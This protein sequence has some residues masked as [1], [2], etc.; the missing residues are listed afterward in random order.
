M[1]IIREYIHTKDEVRI[2]G[3][4]S[5]PSQIWKASL[6]FSLNLALK[7]NLMTFQVNQNQRKNVFL[8]PLVNPHYRSI[9]YP[10]KINPYKIDAHGSR[11]AGI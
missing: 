8:Y 5:H 9:L 4:G 11:R 7:A 3:F 6:K 2:Y 10:C 1:Q